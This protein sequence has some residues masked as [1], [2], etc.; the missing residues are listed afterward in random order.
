MG[1]REKEAG[2]D[3]MKSSDERGNE[4]LTDFCVSAEP[5]ALCIHPIIDAGCNILS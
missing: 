1:E 4:S 3:W 2:S 5:L